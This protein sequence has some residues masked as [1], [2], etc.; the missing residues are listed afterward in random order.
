MAW[1]AIAIGWGIFG[2]WWG[3]VLQHETAHA[4]I[5]AFG[6]IGAL[7]A[8]CVIAMVAWTSYNKRLARKA[9]RRRNSNRYIPIRWERDTLGRPLEL[10]AG[11]LACTAP[12]VRVVLK[13]GVKAYLAVDPEEL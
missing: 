1:S 8:I 12:E 6:L 13:G 5:V 10:P 9:T 3:I 7:L 2:S 11:E 4:L